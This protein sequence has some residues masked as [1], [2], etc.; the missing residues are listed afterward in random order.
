MYMVLVTLLIVVVLANVVLT[1]M[2]SQSRLT[3]HQVSRIQAYYAALAGVNYAVEM[4]RSGSDT[5][6]WPMPAADASYSKTLCRS[7]CDINDTDLPLSVARVDITV[8]GKDVSGCNPPTS[9]I[10]ACISAT[11]D[12]TYTSP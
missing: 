6:N 7:G 11:A 4:L 9:G 10:P 3:H 2:S 12:Y 5:T 8:A 1:I